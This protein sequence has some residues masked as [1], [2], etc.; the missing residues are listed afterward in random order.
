MVKPFEKLVKHLLLLIGGIGIFFMIISL[1]WP[2][3]AVAFSPVVVI[4]PVMIKA[5]LTPICQWQ[6]V[7]IFW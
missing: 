5:G 4:P 2:S 7:L 3:P 6:F 1:F